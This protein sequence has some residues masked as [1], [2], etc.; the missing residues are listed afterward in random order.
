M[1]PNEVEA[2]I[3]NKM[4]IKNGP[5]DFMTDIEFSKFFEVYELLRKKLLSK[6]SVFCFDCFAIVYTSDKKCYSTHK[7]VKSVNRFFKTRYS[8]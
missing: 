2:I 4:V 7:N 8:Y 6:K 5:G 3:R 1:N